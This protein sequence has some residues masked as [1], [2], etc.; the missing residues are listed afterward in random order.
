MQANGMSVGE[1]NTKLLQKVEELT[2]YAIE[3]QKR[4]DQLEHQQTKS[5][6]QDA[7]IA[8]LEKALSKLTNNQSK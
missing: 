3:Q 4:I 6:Q 1:I 7:R 8:V 2:L 5:E